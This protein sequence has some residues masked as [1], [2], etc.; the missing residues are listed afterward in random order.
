MELLRLLE[1]IIGSHVA[2]LELKTSTLP[3][4]TDGLRMVAVVKFNLEPAQAFSP[5]LRYDSPMLLVMF[6]E[7]LLV[8]V[9]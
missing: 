3:L 9:T 5:S 2:Y 7:L 4:P 8:Q 6:V 1:K